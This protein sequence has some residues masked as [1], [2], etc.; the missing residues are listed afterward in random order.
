[1]T[2]KRID[3]VD[4]L[5]TFKDNFFRY[6]KT[7]FTVFAFAALYGTTHS[8]VL[9]LIKLVTSEDFSSSPYSRIIAVLSGL[10]AMV[11]LRGGM[12]ILLNYFFIKFSHELY[13]DYQQKIYDKIHSLPLLFFQK[14]STGD[15]IST[16]TNDVNA[17]NEASLILLSTVTKQFWTILG[18]I[19]VMV[20]IDPYL[21]LL[22]LVTFPVFVFVLKS[23]GRRLR[24]LSIESQKEKGQILSSLTEKLSSIKLIKISG[25]SENEVR[26]FG[27]LNLSFLKRMMLINTLSKI[28]GPVMEMLV[29]ISA[30]AC[31]LWGVHLID[32][33]EME[34]GKLISFMVAIFS[35]YNPITVTS[36]INMAIQR[37]VAGMMRISSILDEPSEQLNKPDMLNINKVGKSIVFD[38]VGFSYNEHKP[39]LQDISFKAFPG[40]TISVVGRTGQGKSTLINLIPRFI[41]PLTGT[42]SFDGIDY[43]NVDLSCL[44]QNIAYVTQEAY[45]FSTSIMDNIRYAFPQAS[46]NDVI[47]AAEKASVHDF[48]SSLPEGYHTPVSEKGLS[49]S[50]GERQRIAL[51]REFLKVSLGKASILILDEAMSE[52]DFQTEKTILDNLAGPDSGCITFIIS[53]RL[54]S[55]MNSSLILVIEGGRIIESGNHQ[56]LMAQQGLYWN[57][58]TLQ[59]RGIYV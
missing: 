47:I 53:H 25:Q 32:Q 13:Y 42:I 15:I 52:V 20:Y 51:A 59:S 57:L 46:E 1:M 43:R 28:S 2:Q 41:E 39:L 50:G 36:G 33:G 26:R 6:R 31:I 4:I 11:L 12:S 27:D 30:T 10:L 29:M 7:T 21:T 44:R 16:I 23:I 34:R 35:L 55:V 5:R 54:V 8:G 9:L 17:V 38:R 48:I 24:N 45:L 3:A 37:A 18:I 56:S 14:K 58:F 49:L 22:S 19:A 40:Q